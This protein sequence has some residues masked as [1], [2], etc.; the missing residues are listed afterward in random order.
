MLGVGP[1]GNQTISRKTRRDIMDSLIADRVNWAGRLE[2]PQFLGRLW[3]LST[4]RST[5]SCFK[6]ADGDIWQHRVNNPQ[7]WPDDWVFHDGRFNLMGSPDE[8]FV[9]FLCEMLHPIVRQDSE[10]IE[11]LLTLF[12]DCLEEDDWEIV[13]IRRRSGRPLYEGRRREAVKTPTA[14]L[15]LDDYPRLDDPQVIR[16]HL[17]RIDRYLKSDPPGAIGSSK[18]LVESV[19]DVALDRARRD[20]RHLDGRQ[21]PVPRRAAA[22]ARDE[23][24]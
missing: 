9:A 4:M 7:D 16:D 10:E 12:N 8:M 19:A 5:D 2:E 18:E 6:D 20:L 22:V 17:R 15:D 11:R 21:L 14:A 23:R 24:G 3:D 1:D 13:A